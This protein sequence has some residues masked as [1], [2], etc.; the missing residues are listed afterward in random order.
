L[1]VDPYMVESTRQLEHLPWIVDNMVNVNTKMTD[2][3]KGTATARIKAEMEQTIEEEDYRNT[4]QNVYRWIADEGLSFFFDLNIAIICEAREIK[5]RL[6]K[7]MSIFNAEA[8]AI[9]EAIKATIRW[10]IAKKIILTNSLSNLMAQEKIYTRGN[11]KIAELKD[12]L[13]EERKNLKIM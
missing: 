10:G 9:L 2:I 7:P 12:L 8:V 5:I 4:R 3:P 13:A 1:E 11:S 6:S